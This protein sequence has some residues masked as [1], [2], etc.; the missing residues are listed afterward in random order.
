MLNTL[1]LYAKLEIDSIRTDLILDNRGHVLI[2]PRKH[3]VCNVYNGH[4][5]TK[6]AKSLTQFDSDGPST[7]GDNP[8][9]EFRE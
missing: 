3:V 2:F 9:R 5:G 8:G 4:F 6:T 1:N 7:D